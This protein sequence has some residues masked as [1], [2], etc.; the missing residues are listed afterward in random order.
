MRGGRVTLKA[1]ARADRLYIE[2]ADDGAGMPPGAPPREG[3]GL[4]NTR[5]RLR[6]SFGADQT[7]A[8]EPGTVG[9]VVARIEIPCRP[10]TASR[11][12]A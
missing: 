5:E 3:I 12:S 11:R 4:S 7:L 1:W 10:Y 6:A 2:V 8:I 9:G